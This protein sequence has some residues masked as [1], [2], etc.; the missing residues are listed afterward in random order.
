MITIKDLKADE[1]HA[2]VRK[3]YGQIGKVDQGGCCCSG[4]AS[5][6]CGE[7]IAFDDVSQVMGYSPEELSSV[8]EE[9]NLGLGCGNPQAI[10]GLKSGENVL[11]LGCGGGLDSFLAAN[12]VGGKGIVI[13][14]D[15]TSEMVSRARL[16]AK[17]GN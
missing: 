8:P 14:V 15:M 10:A 4:P 6:C 12:N 17:K 13:G 7:D 5:S 9:A 11:D 16:N 3:H 2:Q 1:I